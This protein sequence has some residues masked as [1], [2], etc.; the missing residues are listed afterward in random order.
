[1]SNTRLLLSLTAVLSL[2]VLAGC[3]SN[4]PVEQADKGF[5]D[6]VRNMIDQQIYDRQAAANPL[7]DLPASTDG[8]RAAAALKA[9]RDQPSRA[10]API[11]DSAKINVSTQP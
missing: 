7:P 4:P 2:G 9:Y 11:S 6:S 8:Q 5:G 10:N 1:M 3:S